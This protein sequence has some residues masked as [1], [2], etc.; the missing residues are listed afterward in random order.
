MKICTLIYLLLL[1]VAL[2]SL[3]QP[4]DYTKDVLSKESIIDALYQVI[5]GSPEQTRDWDRF[6]NLFLPESR[7]IPTGKNKEGNFTIRAISPEEYV[8][9]FTKNIKTGFFEKELHHE[10]DEYG[11][12]AHVFSTYETRQSETGPVSNRGINSIQL[13]H[14]GKRYYVVNIFWCAESMGFELPSKYLN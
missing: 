14:D 10:V 6:R 1:L 4:A 2:P 12:I 8:Q 11:T 5:S 7:L 13:Y 3:A 9:M